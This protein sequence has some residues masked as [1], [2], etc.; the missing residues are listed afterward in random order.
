LCC[1]I[2][3]CNSDD[4]KSNVAPA[5]T[6][7]SIRRR[8]STGR[9]ALATSA[10]EF[11]LL[12]SGYLKGSMQ[13]DGKTV[14]LD[15]PGTE[16]GQHLVA[17]GKDVDF[18]FDLKNARISE[19]QGKLGKLGKHVEVSGANKRESVRGFDGGSL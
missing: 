18:V 14:T 11:V 5:S 16:S 8:Q 10:A 1:Q 6:N 19:A 4:K 12:P 17:G 3:S 15:D 13:R 9:A 7:S 2:S